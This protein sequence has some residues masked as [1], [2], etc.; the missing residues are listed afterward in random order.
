MD[1]IA[2][3]EI[4]D[5]AGR[6]VARHRVERLPAVIG[7]GYASDVIVDDPAVNP[8]HAR[9]WRDGSGAL[10]LDDLDTV[11]GVA[12]GDGT[13]LQGSIVLDQDRAVR[14][15]GTLLRV[16]QPSDPVAPTRRHA[17]PSPALEP[18]AAPQPA[19]RTLL[20]RLGSAPVAIGVCA[21]AAA[22]FAVDS[23][24]GNS[25]RVTSA[26]MVGG[27]LAILAMLAL[28]AGCWAFASRL[29]T[30][31][32]RFLG[33]LAIA[34]IALAAFVVLF[35]AAGYLSFIAPAG[36]VQALLSLL[37]SVGLFAAVIQAHL[38]LS[39]SLPGRR[40]AG[41][42]IGIAIA[43]TVFA[44]L[45]DWAGADEFDTSLDYAGEIKPLGS[46]WVRGVTLDRFLEEARDLRTEVDD[47]AREANEE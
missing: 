34:S 22:V 21:V 5:A 17:A 23:Y 25:G 19:G 13:P 14:L 45:G 4:L 32:F 42:A 7:R 15:G 44:G 27:A 29:L 36:E 43:L 41:I 16:R 38:G 9:L 18:V 37:V 20:G 1:E 10:R 11:N 2:F 31:R 8:S 30:G 24:L 46:R 28:W 26:Q 3:V 47:M 6:V 33:H 35:A 39:S 12:D 40:R